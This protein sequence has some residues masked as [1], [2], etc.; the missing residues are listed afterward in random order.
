MKTLRVTL[1]P[2]ALVLAA[3]PGCGDGSKSAAPPSEREASR[4]AVR[5]VTLYTSADEV[6]ATPLLSAFEKETGIRVDLIADTEANKTAGLFERLLAEKDR[7]RADVFWNSE[8]SRT[9]MLWDRGLL[10]PICLYE[11][12]L[13]GPRADPPPEAPPREINPACDMA[14]PE[15]RRWIEFAARARVIIVNTV[16]VKEGEAPK[17]MA[18]LA[19]PRWS[20]R[21]ALA[22]PLF[23]TTG[24]HC[25]ALFDSLGEKEARDFFTAL[26]RNGLRVLDGNA[27]VRDAVGRGDVDVGVVDT[28]DALG[29]IARGLPLAMIWPDQDGEKPQ[30]AFLIPNTL[31]KIKG[32]PHPAEADALIEF[33]MRRDTE[34]ALAKDNAGHLPLRDNV[35]VPAGWRRATEI[36]SMPCDFGSLGTKMQERLRTLQEILLKK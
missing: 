22:N 1:L 32:A 14:V 33:L 28:D 7:P 13:P 24:S 34:A 10:H 31:S 30:G 17:R 27:A 23:G 18:D 21:L 35:P 19:D 8:A 3:S 11:A 26:R 4:P 25:A 2:L 20:G 16:H 12:D 15:W 36:R 9:A 29:G 6:F 5:S